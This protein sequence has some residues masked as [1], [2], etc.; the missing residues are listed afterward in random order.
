MPSTQFFSGLKA[1]AKGKKG[2]RLN[3][4]LKHRF[5][6]TKSITLNL[7]TI[8]IVPTLTSVA[9]LVTV[10]LLFLMA[11]NFQNSLIYG[12]S[13]WLLSLLVIT[14]FF[15]YN[16]LSG[17]KIRAIRS[18]PCFAGEKAVFELQLSSASG[19]RKS[20]IFLGW[21]DQD[22]LNISLG[23][24]QSLPVKL[25]HGT[26]SRGYFKPGRISIFTRYPLGLIVAWSYAP[27]DMSCIVYPAPQLLENTK[28]GEN[29]DDLASDGSEIL[30]G[31]NDFSGIRE[32]I[33]GDSPKHIHWGAYAKTGKVYTKSFVDYHSDDHWLDWDSLAVQSVEAKLSH[34][35]A[36]VLSCHQE[37]LTYGL[38]IPGV[39]LV[40]ACNEAH[41]HACLTALALYGKKNT[42]DEDREND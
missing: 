7:R 23:K 38:K 36:R 31:S 40:P 41:K 18:T 27:V 2:S 14:I 22:I 34:L 39:T 12:L 1:L 16:N 28:L 35:A 29:K 15:T 10:L 20:A 4:W 6:E 9:L 37:Q 17:L 5:P 42:P 32:Y 11:T 21:K 25:S 8:F 19:Q 3:S 30:N 26:K 24:E 13:F 33:P